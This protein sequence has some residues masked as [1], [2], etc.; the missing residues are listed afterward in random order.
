MKK[1]W[2]SLYKFYKKL[3]F[4]KR[5]NL[6]KDCLD[7]YYLNVHRRNYYQILKMIYCLNHEKLGFQMI[8]KSR[9]WITYIKKKYLF[10]TKSSCILN[11][12]ETRRISKSKS[13]TIITRYVTFPCNTRFKMTGLTPHVHIRTVHL[14]VC[15]Y[16][17]TYTL[18]SESTLYS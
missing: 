18:Q 4:L 12:A 8:K 13:H 9:T 1:L 5:D 15:I 17:V 11:I 3:L 2:L 6:K 16:H 7:V 14:T 10:A